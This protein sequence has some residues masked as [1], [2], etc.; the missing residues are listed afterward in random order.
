[1]ARDEPADFLKVMDQLAREAVTL[2]DSATLSSLAA[3]L[4]T[5]GQR[6][7]GILVARGVLPITDKKDALFLFEQMLESRD[8]LNLSPDDPFSD[9]IDSLFTE[10]D[11]EPSG[12]AEALRVA[13]HRLE[14][15]AQEVRQ[16]KESLEQLRS[17]IEHREEKPLTPAVQSSSLQGSL[18]EGAL[19][20]LREK[21]SELKCELKQRHNERAV[22]RRELEK[23]HTDLESLRQFQVQHGKPIQDPEE[24]DEEESLILP[25]EVTANQPVRLIEFPRKF[26]SALALIPRQTARATLAILGR[27]AAG[28]PAAFS[29]V[30]RL[31]ACPDI[32]RQRIGIHYRLL[33]RLQPDQVQVVDVINRK[34]LPRR[35]KS[36]T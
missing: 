9:L 24:T 8:K 12:D 26:Q 27:L 20:A 11:S 7:L 1:M 32:L 17:E 30:V 21:V 18:D 6:A 13:R 4:M 23:M 34:D 31:K 5:S 22:L 15:K 16:L 2:N 28:E 36:L 35:I 29:G 10:E 33:F 25:G 14:S 19:H 3:G